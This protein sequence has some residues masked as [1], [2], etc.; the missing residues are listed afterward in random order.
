[1]FFPWPCPLLAYSLLIDTCCFWSLQNALT[2]YISARKIET[3]NVN[4]NSHHL[5]LSNLTHQI[6]CEWAPV[7]R[8]V[9]KTA[10]TATKRKPQPSNSNLSADLV[11][12]SFDASLE[13]WRTHEKERRL[14]AYDLCAQKIMSPSLGRYR[15]RR[16]T[17][18]SSLLS[19]KWKRLQFKEETN[20]EQH[21]I[22]SRL[23]TGTGQNGSWKE[24]A[25]HLP[26]CMC[27]CV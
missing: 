22:M 3:E 7:G 6:I 11:F 14:I 13:R 12:V 4:E 9:N 5:L 24:S 16:R 25:F 26:F 17:R 27:L 20:C 15:W 8:L 23:G 1:M 19:D 10:M 21:A 18:S 2:P